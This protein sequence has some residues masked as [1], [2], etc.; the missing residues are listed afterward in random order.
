LLEYRALGEKLD[1]LQYI[2]SK[3]EEVSK[4]LK[5]E[6]K[7]NVKMVESALVE[8]YKGAIPGHEGPGRPSKWGNFILHKLKTLDRPLTYDEIVLEAEAIFGSGG[9][10]DAQGPSKSVFSTVYRLRHSGYVGTEKI[11][12]KT[13]K[14]IALKAW[15][16]PGGKLKK[17][18]IDRIV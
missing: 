9:G 3:I 5:V 4:D 11:P 15:Y 2:L 12:G 6:L 13:H 1:F 8:S 18:Y 14:Y 17:E 16:T 7:S 10:K